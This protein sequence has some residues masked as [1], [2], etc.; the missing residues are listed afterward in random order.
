MCI[1]F[2]DEEIKPM[3]HDIKDKDGHPTE[4]KRIVI[5]VYYIYSKK[6]GESS[7]PNRVTTF[8]HEIRT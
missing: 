5:P 8:V 1:D 3:I 2:E 6:I 7:G 4:K